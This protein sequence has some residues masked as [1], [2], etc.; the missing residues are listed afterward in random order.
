MCN[1]HPS[2]WLS[3]WLEAIGKDAVIFESKEVELYNERKCAFKFCYPDNEKEIHYTITC[4]E[5]VMDR[6]K[7]DTDAWPA[8]VTFVEK[9]GANGRAYVAYE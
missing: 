6:L 2:A 7:K 3:C 8:V 9:K 1:K 4:S 5:V